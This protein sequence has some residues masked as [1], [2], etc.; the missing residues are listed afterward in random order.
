MSDDITKAD[1]SASATVAWSRRYICKCGFKGRCSA[2]RRGPMVRCAICKKSTAARPISETLAINAA[3]HC[4]PGIK[5][6]QGG[7]K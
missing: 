7:R 1:P 2:A 4:K 6:T 3:L 5:L